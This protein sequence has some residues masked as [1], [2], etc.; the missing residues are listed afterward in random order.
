MPSSPRASNPENA[1]ESLESEINP[2]TIPRA[3]E[4]R[5]RPALQT[6]FRKIATRRSLRSASASFAA[7][8]SQVRQFS[9]A[10]LL[11]GETEFFTDVLAS[12]F[13]IGHRGKQYL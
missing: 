7:F 1:R 9:A 11:E 10:L 2:L 12:G 6:W 8:S 4:S 3:I 13:A 5:L